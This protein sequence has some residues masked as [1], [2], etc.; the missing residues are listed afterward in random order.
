MNNKLMFSSVN[1]KWETPPDLIKDLKA[2]FDIRLDVCA[3]RS[4]V[5]E[6]FFNEADNGLEQDWNDEGWNWCNPPYSGKYKSIHWLKKGYS[7]QV[8]NGRKTLFLIPSRTDTEL[9]HEWVTVSDYI[10]FIRGRLTFGS[11]EF[12]IE[13][14]SKELE[15]MPMSKKKVIA[16]TKKIGGFH[17]NEK[18][19]TYVGNHL[20]SKKDMGCKYMQWLGSKH[21]KP[22]PAPFGSMIVVYGRLS[23][24]E[25]EKLANLGAVL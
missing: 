20:F 12:W 11:K 18:T 15:K 4:N 10:F 24:G 17:V 22:D 1:Q 21:V 3:S 7:Q 5:C 19:R 25:F 6:Q 14:Y 16:L 13:H 2:V 23:E 9:F 8:N